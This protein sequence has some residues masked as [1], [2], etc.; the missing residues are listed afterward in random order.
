MNDMPFLLEVVFVRLYCQTLEKSAYNSGLNGYG[1]Y[2][3]DMG[4]EISKLESYMG[5]KINPVGLEA[6]TDV[7]GKLNQAY[8]RGRAEKKTA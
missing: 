6:V 1:G 4:E 2:P 5:G 8:E 3:L 7:V